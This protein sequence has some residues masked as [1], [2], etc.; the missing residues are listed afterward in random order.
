M[1]GEFFVE[2]RPYQEE[3]LLRDEEN[4]TRYAKPEARWQAKQWRSTSRILSELMGGGLPAEVNM[5]WVKRVLDIACD[6]GEW[7]YEVALRYPS[8]EVFG[9]DKST[10]SIEDAKMRAEREYI[11]NIEYMVQ[12]IEP[13]VGEWLVRAAYHLVHM[14]FMA[15]ELAPHDFPNLLSSL[16]WLCKP[17]GYLLWTE[18]ELPITNSTVYNHYF[19][20]IKTYM[21]SQDH[22][23]IPGMLFGITAFMRGWMQKSDFKNIT[24]KTYLLDSTTSKETRYALIGQ[25]RVFFDSMKPKLIAAGLLSKEENYKLEEQIYN[26]YNHDDFRAVCTIHSL[27]GVKGR[28]YSNQP[29]DTKSSKSEGWSGVFVSRTP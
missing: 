13:F 1:R 9:I 7:A 4:K 24:G 21:Q 19:D 28:K 27:L 8:V 25:M 26:E 12:D 10:Q 14:R 3:P 16:H 29:R 23:F 6:D 5:Q 2:K 22:T 15:G 17:G 11:R 20:L 18:A